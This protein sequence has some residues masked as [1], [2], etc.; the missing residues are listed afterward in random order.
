MII[1]SFFHANKLL[2]KRN[3][4]IKESACI[5]TVLGSNEVPCWTGI[6]KRELT[7]VIHSHQSM[8]LQRNGFCL[9]GEKLI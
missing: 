9:S 8:F 4:P 6:K 7:L 2:V 1:D 3:G 5:M